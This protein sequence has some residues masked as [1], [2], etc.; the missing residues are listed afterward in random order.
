MLTYG[1]TREALRQQQGTVADESVK[2][3][4]EAGTLP[5]LQPTLDPVFPHLYPHLC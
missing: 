3:A 4:H 2:V 1:Q 5:Q